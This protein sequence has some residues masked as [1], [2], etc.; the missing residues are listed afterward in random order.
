I[1]MIW[2]ITPAGNGISGMNHT[3]IQI[4]VD[5]KWKSIEAGGNLD[6]E[7]HWAGI[8]NYDPANNKDVTWAWDGKNL[9]RF[10]VN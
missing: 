3:F 7:G 1:R 4:K 9:H 5:G 8:E 6:F 2:N 10:W